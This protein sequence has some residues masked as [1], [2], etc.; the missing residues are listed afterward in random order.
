MREV[1]PLE[2]RVAGPGGDL[3]VEPKA[4]AV[5][6]E[7]ARHAPD[8]CPR[9]QIVQ[10]VWPRG[11]VTDDVLTRCIGQ[12][13][14]ALGDDPRAP[15][16][17]ETIPK[18]GY[19][20]RS[21]VLQPRA[22]SDREHR[23]AP[24]MES[25]IVLPFQN[26]SDASEDFVADGLTE[27]LT[28]RLA[29]LQGIRVISRTTAMQ[30]KASRSSIGEI[31]AMTGADWAIEGSVLQSGNR[32]QVVA[33]LI[34]A[35]TDG[36]I[37]AAD[38][39]RDLQ[40]LLPLQNEIAR[41]VGAAIRLKLGAAAEAPSSL[42]SISPADMR[43]YLRGRHLMSKRTV[44]NLRT[45]LAEFLSLTAA[46]P[47]HAA[48]WAS[49]AECEMLLVHYDA[50]DRE[51]L[52]ANCENHLDRALTLD[53]ELAI[54]LSTRGA[55]RFFFKRDFAG[56]AADLGHALALLPS[57]S[58]AMVS[59]ANVCVARRQFD[60]AASWMDQA[61]LVDPL[62]VGV[63]MN[64]ADHCILRRQYAQ[65]VTALERTLELAPQHRPSQLRLCWALAL[66]GQRSAAAQLLAQ[67]GPRGDSDAP[68]HEYAAMV[69]GAEGDHEV[70]LRH[71]EV[72]RDIG[73]T[74]RVPA[75][76]MA[77]AAAAAAQLDAAL[78]QL[79]VAVRD[80]SSSIPFMVVTPAFDALH[81]D[82][83]FRTLGAELGLPLEAS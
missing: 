39:V 19:R 53:P 36:H 71:Y 72:L 23:V 21:A 15:A 70:A 7:L 66:C 29:S 48:G 69:A 62:D 80:R 16:C 1:F 18:R 27:L 81:A 43:T 52:F 55:V 46:A 51:Q 20:L 9:E 42:P 83:R 68:W 33:Q 25:L 2:G 24:R 75:W 74:E 49:A 44:P 64:L 28:L 58:L 73:L 22:A 31:A 34:D 37:W 76:T 12:I 10:S 59:L 5:L 63:N 54:G 67:I 8:I 17:V 41:R 56:A 65:A 3:R 13:R 82:A 32:L 26:L 4:M 6:V 45:A 11:Y 47:D 30:F 14:R 60:E 50:P 40:E 35:R 57:Y 77:R 79:G 61:L 38:Y 78:A